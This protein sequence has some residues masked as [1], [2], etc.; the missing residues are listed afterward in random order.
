MLTS[1]P[2][3]LWVNDASQCQWITS[4]ISL[5]K[6]WSFLAIAFFL[7]MVHDCIFNFAKVYWLATMSLTLQQTWGTQGLTLAVKDSQVFYLQ[8]IDILLNFGPWPKLVGKIWVRS[9][10]KEKKVMKAFFMKNHSAEY[11]I[12]FFSLFASNLMYLSVVGIYSLANVYSL[13]NITILLAISI[14]C[15]TPVLFTLIFTY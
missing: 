7:T 14:I 15:L 5:L 2:Q 6:G 9:N 1:I 12:F 11:F 3:D 10:S 8:P 4:L 13:P